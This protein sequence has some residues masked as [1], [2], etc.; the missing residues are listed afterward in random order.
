MGRGGRNG[1]ALCFLCYSPGDGMSAVETD[2]RAFLGR[3]DT[4]RSCLWGKLLTHFSGPDCKRQNRLPQTC[5]SWCTSQLHHS[6]LPT[7]TFILSSKRSNS[8]L[9]TTNTTP[10]Q[11]KKNHIHHRHRL[12]HPTHHLLTEIFKTVLVL[13]CSTNVFGVFSDKIN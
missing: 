4:P 1:A 7:N 5:C 8:D 3:T 10:K 13:S 12:L 11:A 6:P 9:N 2:M